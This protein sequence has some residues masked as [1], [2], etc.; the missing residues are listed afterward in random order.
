MTLRRRGHFGICA[1]KTL[2]VGNRT[3]LALGSAREAILLKIFE[4]FFFTLTKRRIFSER[5][6]FTGC[7]VIGRYRAFVANLLVAWITSH[8]SFVLIIACLTFALS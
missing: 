8:L 1:G 2:R 5:I 3:S 6:M 4:I 7:T